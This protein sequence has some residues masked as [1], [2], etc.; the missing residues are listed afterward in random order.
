MYNEKFN[1][2]SKTQLSHVVEGKLKNAE[3]QNFQNGTKLAEELF[4]EQT[5]YIY[6][7]L[8][9]PVTVIFILRT[10]CVKNINCLMSIK[11]FAFGT[12][13]LKLK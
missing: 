11:V 6:Y 1:N 9:Y 7:K 3:M 12:K 2:T 8:L 13:L 5:L 4:D 10:Q